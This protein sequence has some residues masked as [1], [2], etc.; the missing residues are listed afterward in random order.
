MLL[1]GIDG[2]PLGTL[3]RFEIDA[4]G[5]MTSIVVRGNDA[6]MRRIVSSQ[7]HDLGSRAITVQMT[8]ADFVALPEIETP[9]LQLDYDDQPRLSA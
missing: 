1:C 4:T 2:T 7:V 9:P 5:Q 3:E 8:A 6:A